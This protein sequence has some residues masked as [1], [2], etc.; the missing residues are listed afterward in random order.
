L[1]FIELVNRN[2]SCIIAPHLGGAVMRL[3]VVKRGSV[4][5]VLRPTPEGAT[6]PREFALIHMAPMGGAVRD[7]TF[8]WDG[9]PKTLEPNLPDFPFFYNGV[10]WQRPW[11]GKKDG[12]YSA[13]LKYMHK[14]APGW[15]FDFSATAVFDLEED[16]LAITYE[17]ANESKQGTYPI[18][19]GSSFLLPR[20]KN[21]LLSAG[22][23]SIWTTDSHGVPVTLTEV[24]YELDIKEGL[25]LNGVDTPERWFTGWTGKAS[26]DYAES[27]LSVTVKA[28]DPL[29]WLGL[30]CRKSDDFLRLTTLS[31]VPGVLDIRGHDEEETGWRVLGPGESIS[32]QVK[33]DV[34]LNMY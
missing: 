26:I 5:N 29:S 33:I 13:T 34:D 32:G 10:A 21:I 3:D 7:N 12:K 27:K 17:M 6:D 1:S 23:S 15:P 30:A 18:G 22:V 9:K 28:G 11:T 8:K 14:Q 25:Q 31:H 4:I 20:Q 2:L 19:F 16:N 24:P